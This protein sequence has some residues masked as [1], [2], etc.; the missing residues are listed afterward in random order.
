MD[1]DNNMIHAFNW[2]CACEHCEVIKINMHD[3]G[4]CCQV[5]VSNGFGEITS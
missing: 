4:C 1:M 2:D 5:C 3:E